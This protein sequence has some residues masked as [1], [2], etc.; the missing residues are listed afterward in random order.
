MKTIIRILIAY[1]MVPQ[2][3]LM[4]LQMI[5]LNTL[6]H[7]KIQSGHSLS[8]EHLVPEKVYLSDVF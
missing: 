6:F 2:K 4:R 1:Y 7:L 3:L 5:S 8:R